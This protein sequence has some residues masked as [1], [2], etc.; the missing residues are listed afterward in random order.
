MKINEI[1]AESTV[2]EG[3]V[4]FAKKVGGAF[5]AA[6]QGYQTS[7][8]SRQQ[9]DQTT[10]VVTTALQKWIAINQNILASGQQS[11][12]TQAVQWYTNFSGKAPTAPPA[13]T[14]DTVMKQWLAK[15]ISN[16]MAI[17]ALGPAATPPAPTRTGGKVAGKVSQ[18]A[19]AVRQ[20]QARANKTTVTPQP[21]VTP[22]PTIGGLGPNDP[23]Y[24]ALAAATKNASAT[25][26]V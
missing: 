2:D 1:L 25:P 17:R 5:S 4:D 23:R 6:K 26:T 9:A 18:S 10:K 7:Q 8:V 3:F 21:K 15:E 20:R 22:Q 16:F 11:T 13:N 19:S 24:A 14:T 12:P